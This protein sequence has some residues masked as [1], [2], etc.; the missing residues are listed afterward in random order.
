MI[1]VY[2]QIYD[3]LRE[4]QPSNF[5]KLIPISGDIAKENLGLSPVDRQMLTERVTIIIHSAANIKFN[6]SL[7]HT[8]L[9][10]TRS[11]RDICDLAKNMK[12]LIVSKRENDTYI[13]FI[14]TINLYYIPLCVNYLI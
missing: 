9:T 12:N 14:F 8:I 11:T 13:F 3:K 1:F 4:N 2:S 10:N 6:N 7:K 5:K